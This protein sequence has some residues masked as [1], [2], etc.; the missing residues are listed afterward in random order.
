M[1][2]LSDSTVPV[3]ELRHQLTGRLRASGVIRTAGVEAAF[4]STPRHL[5]LPGVPVGA[6]YA[7]NPVYTKQD[8]SGVN[9]SAASQPFIVA[10][11]LEQLAVQPGDRIME[12]G[13][14]T[15][16]NAA[17]MAAM[18]GPGGHVITIDVDEDLVTGAREHLAAAQVTNV[19]VVLGDGALG[20]PG[21]A[22]YDKIIAT[23]G[24]A[25]VPGP[26]LQ[27]LAPGGRLVVPLRLRGTASRS[28]IFE[29]RENGWH[30][31][32]SRLAVF[33]PMRGSHDDAR[34]V[35]SLTQGTDVTLQVH[36]DQ[37]AEA[38][39]LA[40]V[41]DTARH[42]EWTGVLFPPDVPYEWMDLWLC[43]RLPNA[44]MRMN[45]Q[46]PAADRSQVTPMFGWGSMA[47]VD[48]GSLAYLTARPAPAAADG[49]KRY[50]VGVI[51]HGPGGRP[52]GR[53][54]SDEISLWDSQYRSRTVHFELPDNP[55]SSDPASGTFVLP[56]P[57]RPITVT[58]Q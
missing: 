25:E 6:A 29:R 7:D 53:H 26:W 4:R 22:P 11:M 17:L 20:H 35:I 33:M 37:E 10:T 23:V 5:F 3:S 51:G 34:R 57:S 31:Q 18:A 38:D 41:L 46:P 13:A 36:Q 47:T 2:T 50:E 43:L 40:G 16:Y 1:T 39:A 8:G 21:G 24:A 28:I 45:V 54:V 9:I 42:E 19:D 15:G 14:G 30:S 52:L 27:Q 12:A 56:R 58:W 48:R 44:L 32:G 55:A 49:G